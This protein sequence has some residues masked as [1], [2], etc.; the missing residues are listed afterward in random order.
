MTIEPG[1]S[2]FDSPPSVPPGALDDLLDGLP[3][4]HYAYNHWGEVT[5]RDGQFH[6]RV[7]VYGH[8]VDN[9]SA[10]S[11]EA[12]IGIVNAKWGAD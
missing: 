12:L 9:I 7:M 2:N 5:F 6:E 11:L 4:P 3:V 10:D 1:I 8:T